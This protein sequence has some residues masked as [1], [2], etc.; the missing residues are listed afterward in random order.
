MKAKSKFHYLKIWERHPGF[1]NFIENQWKGKLHT[2]PLINFSLKLSKLRKALRIWN[3]EV[4]GDIN[5]KEDDV[6]K[7][8]EVTQ[9]ALE[10]EWTVE[11][12]N[13]LKKLRMELDDIL[14]MK[15]SIAKEKARISW[16][17]DGDRNT[18]FFHESIRARCKQNQMTL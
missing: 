2:Q 15:E 7:H 5:R 16:L 17:K 3:R 13:N 1:L 11:N 14:S 8:I 4:S 18:A 9:H 10:L 6:I 12:F